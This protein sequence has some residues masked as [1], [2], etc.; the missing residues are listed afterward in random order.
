MHSASLLLGICRERRLLWRLY[1]VREHGVLQWRM[2]LPS[3][4][5]AA[6]LEA[7]CTARVISVYASNTFARC[8]AAANANL[9]RT[10]TDVMPDRGDEGVS[11]PHSG[12]PNSPKAQIIYASTQRTIM[13]KLPPCTKRARCSLQ[14][15]DAQSS[16]PRVDCGLTQS[17]ESPMALS[18]VNTLHQNQH[19]AR[20]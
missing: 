15:R 8:G 13:F 10:R 7:S 12:T 3:G 20:M 19:L 17:L 2:S 16:M 6:V 18:T 1:R 4:A 11:E 5:M 9:G 14:R